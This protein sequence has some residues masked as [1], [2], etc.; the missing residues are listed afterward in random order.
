MKNNM[1]KLPVGKQVFENFRSENFLY[2]DKTE[3]IYELLTD[4]S[5]QIFMSRPRRFG[6]TLLC[7]TLDAIFSGKKELFEGLAISKTDWKWSV[8]PVIRLDMSAGAYS[9]GAKNAQNAI[10]MLL[11]DNAQK[12]GIDLDIEDS[13]P[14]QFHKLI[15]ESTKKYGQKAVIIVDEYDNPLLSVI[16]KKEEFEKTREILRDFYKIIKVS[17][18]N[19]RFAFLTGITK[20]AQVSVF[21]ALNNLTDITLD[22][23]FADICGITQE[24]MEYNFAPFVDKYANNYDGKE[25]YVKMLKSFYNGYRFSNNKLSVYNPFGLIKHFKSGEFLPYWYE[26]GTPGYLIKLLDTEKIDILTFRN[27]TVTVADFRKYDTDNFEAVPILYQSGYLTIKDY[28]SETQLFTLDYPN[29]EV[30]A[31]FTDE[32]AVQ[33]LG[34]SRTNK[35]ALTANLTKYLFSGDIESAIELAIKP[36][37]AEIPNNLAIKEEKYF[38]TIFHIIFNMMGLKCR[39]EVSIATG[40]IDAVIETPRFVYCF[41]FKLD[42]TVKQALTQIDENEYLTPYIGG[43]KTLFKVGVN[44][45]YEERKIENWAF[46]KV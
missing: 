37:M 20:F 14:V 11:S 32:L 15:K 22:P 26:S 3:R 9:E 27:T 4:D 30:R 36:F 25:N 46:E 45:N 29:T 12:L 6:K 44:F 8:H 2:V 13:L 18:E 1:P 10:K 17:E 43:T 40:R 42:K 21:S 5:E 19:I 7:W 24:E 34:V 41:E 31:S 16:D 33:Y 35:N 39:S 23:Q 28:E 38:Q